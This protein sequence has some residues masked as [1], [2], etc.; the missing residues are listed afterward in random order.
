MDAETVLRAVFWVAAYLLTF[1]VMVL[2]L[3]SHNWSL[4][5]GVICGAFGAAFQIALKKE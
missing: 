5:L 3:V 2:A 1:G 4:L